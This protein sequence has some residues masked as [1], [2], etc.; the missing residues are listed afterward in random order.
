MNFMKMEGIGND[1]IV[2]HEISPDEVAQIAQYAVKICDRRWGIGGDGLIF[3]LPSGD[4]DFRMRMFNSDGSEAEM[5][6]NG[7]R[8]FAKYVDFQGLNANR[9]LTIETLAGVITTDSLDNGTVRVNMGFPRFSAPE[10][11]VAGTKDRVVMYPLD[12]DGVCFS[13]TA[14]SM[15]NPHAVIYDRELSDDLVLGFGPRI[16]KHPFFPQKTNVEFITVMSDTE[17]RMRVWERGCGETQ[18]CGTGA[19]AAVVAGIVNKLHGLTVTVHLPGGDLLVE[20][21]GGNNDPVMMTGPARPV[22]TG[23]IEL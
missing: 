11:P 20:W 16:E 18:A 5:C 2:T 1:F 21:Q 8:C 3:V 15:G 13:I 14:V 12:I 10:L 17:I 9:H 23:V 4:A 19:C 7:I 22:F 6:G